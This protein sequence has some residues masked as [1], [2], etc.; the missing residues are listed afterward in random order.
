[1]EAKE[2]RNLT[3]GLFITYICI[4]IWILLFKMSFS[5]NEIDHNRSIN[6][7]PFYGSVVV[8]GKVYINEIINNILVF[9]PVGIY[10]CML[11]QNWSII[12][13]SL[14]AFILS[15]G[16]ES[17]QFI[18]AIGATDITDIIGNTLGGVMGIGIFYLFAKIFKSKVISIFNILALVATVGLVGMLS[19]S[20]YNEEND[21]LGDNDISPIEITLNDTDTIIEP[22]YNPNNFDDE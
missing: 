21:I 1:M 10:I 11:K 17:L 20:L 18:F 14:V 19:I 16:I 8:N 9:V 4:L 13:K 22:T 7:I 5:F 3:R 6:L 15:F 2:Q 12:Q